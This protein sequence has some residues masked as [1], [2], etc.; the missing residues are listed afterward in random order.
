MPRKFTVEKWTGTEVKILEMS[1]DRVQESRAVSSP[2]G[3][4]PVSQ[5]RPAEGD[6]G[7]GVL[8]GVK[9]PSLSYVAADEPAANLPGEQSK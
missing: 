4:V 7:Y 8:S 6:L 2:R 1:D 5:P 3:L 9:E